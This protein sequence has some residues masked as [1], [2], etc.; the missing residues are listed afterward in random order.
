[1][2]A[3]RTGRRIPSDC[4]SRTRP[5]GASVPQTI[6]VAVSSRLFVPLIITTGRIQFCLAQQPW[7]SGGVV[8]A[9]CTYICIRGKQMFL[10][11]VVKIPFSVFTLYGPIFELYLKERSIK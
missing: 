11:V 5:F 2:I 6:F 9:G 4:S 8:L 1:M 10:G 7:T 3:N